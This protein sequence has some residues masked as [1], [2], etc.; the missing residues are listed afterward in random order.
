MSDTTRTEVSQQ[1]I[2]DDRAASGAPLDA[3]DLARARDP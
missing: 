1:T 3:Q 2:D